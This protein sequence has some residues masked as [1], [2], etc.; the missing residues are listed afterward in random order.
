M[1]S[2]VDYMDNDVTLLL[3]EFVNNRKQYNKVIQELH[4]LIDFNLHLMYVKSF[5][6]IPRS[7]TPAV[8]IY[9]INLTKNILQE[10]KMWSRQRSLRSS[11]RTFMHNWPSVPPSSVIHRN[12]N[13][14]YPIQKAFGGGDNYY[15]PFKDG[16]PW[17]VKEYPPNKDYYTLESLQLVKLK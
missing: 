4:Q 1:I 14:L 13:P 17:K 8:Q 3:G 9:M 6:C 7:I 12:G 5:D 10:E 11:F 2:V 16:R 15:I